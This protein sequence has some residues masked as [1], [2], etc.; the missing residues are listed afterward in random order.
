MKKITLIILTLILFFGFFVFLLQSRPSTVDN[1]KL[2]VTA[3]FYPMYFF[4]NQIGGDKVQVTNITPTGAEPHDYDLTSQDIIKIQ[5]SKLLILNGKVET[6]ADKIKTNLKNKNTKVLI[7]GENLG[8]ETDPH[9]WL[10]PHLAKLESEKIAD[11]LEKIDP[12]NSDYYKNN[13]IDL[14]NK[15]NKIDANYKDGLANCQLK[16]FVTSHAAFGYLAKDYR[17]TQVA[18]EGLSPDAEPSLSELVQITD[19]VRKNNVKII[20]F[21]SL[22][23]PKLSQTI[24]NE[25]GAKTLVLDPIEGVINIK[26]NYLTLMANNLQNLRTALQ[27][28]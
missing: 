8:T 9:I 11:S 10:S 16:S 28:K 22:V 14:E 18:I 15:L 3:S 27:C 13:L 5:N 21:E 2:Q 26:D 25:V 7:A 1:S 12:A 24:A 4:A 23:S 19:F 6:W 20:F 17:L